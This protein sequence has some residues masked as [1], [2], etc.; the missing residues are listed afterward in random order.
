[1]RAYWPAEEALRYGLETPWGRP[2]PDAQLLQLVDRDVRRDI[3]ARLQEK[4]G[5]IRFRVAAR[6]APKALN[7]E[8]V[9]LG[10]DLS[11]L[12]FRDAG[13]TGGLSS[14][15]VLSCARRVYPSSACLRPLRPVRSALSS[16][17]GQDAGLT[18][19]WVPNA[20]GRG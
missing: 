1:M 9:G 5:R 11:G 13:R 18:P 12:L 6:G 19:S 15:P 16:R 14:T 4:V 10:V 2:R 7:E 8:A 20:I 17:R 3:D